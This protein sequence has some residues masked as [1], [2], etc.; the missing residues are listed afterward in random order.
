MTNCFECG[1]TTSY[2]TLSNLVHLCLIVLETFKLV[3]NKLKYITL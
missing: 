2:I 3:N 1:V